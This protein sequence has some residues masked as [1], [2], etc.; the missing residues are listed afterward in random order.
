MLVYGSTAS[1]VCWSSTSIRRLDLSSSS[2][3]EDFYS[4]L[5]L[6]FFLD[7]FFVLIFVDLDCTKE[8]GAAGFVS[9]TFASFS[10]VFSVNAAAGTVSFLATGVAC[11]GTATDFVCTTET[12][13]AFVWLLLYLLSNFS[14]AFLS[15]WAFQN[16]LKFSGL[17][18]SSHFFHYSS[19]IW[20]ADSHP[21]LVF[22]F[23]GGQS[24]EGASPVLKKVLMLMMFF[25]KPHLASDW[26]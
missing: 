14:A 6:C 5:W 10:L 13:D 23:L 11:S 4:F 12:K 2:Y 24:S 8:T 3:F 19:S 20:A 17:A 26:A 15:F 21:F 16:A 18:K 1:S 9:F 25:R 7:F 22:I